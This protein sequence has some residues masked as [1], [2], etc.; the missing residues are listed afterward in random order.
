MTAIFV[1]G[2]LYSPDGVFTLTLRTRPSAPGYTSIT[3]PMVYLPRMALLSAMTTRS[4]TSTFRFSVCHAFLVTSAGSTSRLQRFQKESTIFC[5]NST[6]RRGF[7]VSLNGPWGTSDVARPRSMSLGHRYFPSSGSFGTRPIG[8]WCTRFPTS[9][10]QVYS[11]NGV[12]TCSPIAFFKARLQ[13]LTSAS[14]HPFWLGAAGVVN[15]Q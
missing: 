13:L 3:L 5:T 1:T 9:R 15:I 11:S 8:R 10:R 14:A 4:S 6:R 7:F 2:R 12:R